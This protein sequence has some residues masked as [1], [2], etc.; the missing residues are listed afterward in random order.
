M[1]QPGE[2]QHNQEA[3]GDAEAGYRVGV[4]LGELEHRTVFRASKTASG[5]ISRMLSSIDAPRL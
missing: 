4:G 2:D 1:G 5:E 3:A